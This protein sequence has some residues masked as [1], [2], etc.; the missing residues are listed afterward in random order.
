MNDLLIP[1]VLINDYTYQESI[2]LNKLDRIKNMSTIQRV[3]HEVT[4]E[5]DNNAI[6][7]MLKPEGFKGEAIEIVLSMS[8]GIPTLYVSMNPWHD[9]NCEISMLPEIGVKINKRENKPFSDENLALYKEFLA[10]H[11]RK[12]LAEDAAHLNTKDLAAQHRRLRR[13]KL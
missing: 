1:K 10:E 11:A 6:I 8:A 5:K 13:P 7:M 4:V 3:A 9:A 2:E 12:H